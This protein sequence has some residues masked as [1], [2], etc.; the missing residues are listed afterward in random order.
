M[1]IYAAITVGQEINGRNVVVRT[2]F[3]SKNK[4]EVEDF[5]SKNKGSW[6][7][8]IDVENQKINFFCERHVQQIEVKE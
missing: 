5:L 3:A 6:T 4:S 7:E 1:L 2:D 8:F